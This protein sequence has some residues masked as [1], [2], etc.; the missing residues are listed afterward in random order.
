MKGSR[1]RFPF[2]LFI[3]WFVLGISAGEFLF[4]CNFIVRIAL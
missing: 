3:G 1:L 2:M 4:V